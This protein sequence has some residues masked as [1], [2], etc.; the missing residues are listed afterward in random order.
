M[1][2]CPLRLASFETNGKVRAGVERDG[3]YVE[4]ASLGLPASM[5][6]FL[7]LGPDGLAQLRQNSARPG[8][9]VHAAGAVKLHAPMPDPR[10]IICLGLNYKDHAKES[11]AAIP[12][13][14]I[15]FSKYP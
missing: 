14:P 15:L 5:R 13:E 12:A 2:G 7:A 1:G 9:S 8:I 10:K 3:G 6:D 11:G 4:F